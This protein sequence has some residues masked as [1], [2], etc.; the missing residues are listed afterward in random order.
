MSKYIRTKNSIYQVESILRDNGFV[1]GYVVGEMAFIRN[2]QVIKQADTIE[3]LCDEF[4][5][6]YND[7]KQGDIPIPWATYEKRG[8]WQKERENVVKEIFKK[9]RKAILYG[10]IFTDKGLIYVA[11]MND[12]GD[13][14]LL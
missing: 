8:I 4:V 13:L 11:K 9:D 3:E 2:D 12:K 10:A 5:L 7:V 6:F 14:E 1:K